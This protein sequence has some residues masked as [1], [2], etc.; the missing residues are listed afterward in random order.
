MWNYAGTIVYLLIVL[1]G[2]VEGSPNARGQ[3]E[4][5]FYTYQKS[6]PVHLLLQKRYT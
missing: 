2:V 1:S 4:L 3:G 5:Y 6:R